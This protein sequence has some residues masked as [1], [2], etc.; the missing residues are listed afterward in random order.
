MAARIV[1]ADLITVDR[2][3]KRLALGRKLGATHTIN[4]STTDLAQRLRSLAVD[5][6]SA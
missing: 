4:A 6:P 1:E 3:Q 2:N 5:A